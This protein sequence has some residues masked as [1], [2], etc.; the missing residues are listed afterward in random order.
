MHPQR[1]AAADR[2]MLRRLRVPKNV[3]VCSPCH[4]GHRIDRLAAIARVAD[5]FAEDACSSLEFKTGVNGSRG[6]EFPSETE[7][8]K[9]KRAGEQTGESFRHTRTEK[10]IKTDN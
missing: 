2:I 4:L 10:P 3:V 1:N 8:T 5:P 9:R 6:G 7:P